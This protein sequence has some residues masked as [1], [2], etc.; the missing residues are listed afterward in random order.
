FGKIVVEPG[1]V[2][3]LALEDTF[4]RLQQRLITMTADGGVA[5]PDLHLY[6]EW[7]HMDADGLEML[8]EKIKSIPNLRLVIIDTLAKFKPPKPKN[9]TLYDFDYSV[10]S[11][12]TQVAQ[13]NNVCIIIVHHMR[14]MESED[15]FD[16]IS[17]SF[18][19]TGA[20]DATALLLRT[21]GQA[22]AEL[23]IN[24]RDLEPEE[25]A[26]KFDSQYLSWNIIGK[27]DDILST[28]N[29]QKVF[30][31]IHQSSE[32]ITPKQVAEKTRIHQKYAQR[33]M[34]QLVKE[35]NLKKVGHGKYKVPT[36]MEG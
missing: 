28:D 17:G 4:R 24:G 16:D 12:I 23:R 21:I 27:M 8:E 33:L 31:A 13:N 14:K 34:V 11:R 35:G 6:T 25:I 36:I 2:L 10:V 30:T 26:L 18:G 15:R 9:M 29:K 32:P 3:Y 7:P 5:S 19:V 20:A 1:A 22:D